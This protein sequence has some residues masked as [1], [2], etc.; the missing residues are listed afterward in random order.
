[1][2]VLRVIGV[3]RVSRVNGVIRVIRVIRVIS[4]QVESSQ[5]AAQDITS[6]TSRRIW[7]EHLTLTFWENT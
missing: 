6:H 1:M 2:R 4:T 7:Y 5:S 3:I